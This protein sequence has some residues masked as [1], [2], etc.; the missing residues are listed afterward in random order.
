M[1]YCIYL[2]MQEKHK[3]HLVQKMGQSYTL[4]IFIHSI[5]ELGPSAQ[6]T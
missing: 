3:N 1:G 5:N 6:K 4:F 2:T